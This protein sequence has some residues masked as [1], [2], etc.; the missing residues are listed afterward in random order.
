MGGWTGEA[1]AAEFEELCRV[2]QF[3][4]EGST[5]PV[6]PT[7]NLAR[8]AVTTAAER[9]STPWIAVIPIKVRGP[10]PD[11]E[12]LAEDLS[13]NVAN[14]LARFSYLKVAPESSALTGKR[15]GALR[16]RRLRSKSRTLP[17]VDDSTRQP[18]QRHPG[19]GW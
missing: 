14:G 15:A 11:L 4:L 13:E 5:E 10:D 2:V 19:L 12:D 6:M 1:E 7:A 8:A 3:R 9:A 16:A 18:G 17:A